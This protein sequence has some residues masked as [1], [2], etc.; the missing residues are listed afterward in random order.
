VIAGMNDLIKPRFDPL[1]LRHNLVWT[2]GRLRTAGVVVLTAKL[3]DPGRLLRLPGPLHRRLTERVAELNAAVDAAAGGDPGVLVVDLSMHDEAY[4]PS[5]FDVD[6]VHPGPRGH[7]LLAREFAERLAAAGAP[8]AT[9][10]SLEGPPSRPSRLDHAV[11][12]AAVGV[13]WL[14]GRTTRPLLGRTTQALLDRSTRQPREPRASAQSAPRGLRHVSCLPP[15]S[16]LPTV[17]ECVPAR[18][19]FPGPPSSPAGAT[20]GWLDSSAWTT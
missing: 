16:A 2:V 3:H 19:P 9:L 15:A 8:I 14:L 17:G 20:R 5:T 6:R 10:P 18:F 11:W 12:L 4:L 13:P 1:A 7:R